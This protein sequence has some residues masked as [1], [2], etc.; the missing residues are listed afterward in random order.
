ML[1][2]DTS[3]HV[4]AINATEASSSESQ[5]FL[6]YVQAQQLIVFSPTLLRVE[7]AAA[8]A[9]S[10]GNLTKAV[11]F[12][13][14]ISRQPNYRWIV[15]DEVLAQEAAYI[16]AAYRLKGA[17]AVYAAVAQR[18]GC[19]LVTLDQQQL[20]RLACV[21]PVQ[22]PGAALDTLRAARS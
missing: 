17:D 3:V 10:S 7:L 6:S 22:E 9:R 2:I 16:G 8:V 13:Q 11:S 15:L 18:H 20:Q 14:A 12:S 4:N 5:D 19:T 1:T 21:I